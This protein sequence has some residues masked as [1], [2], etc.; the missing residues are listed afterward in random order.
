MWLY[1][2][3]IVY[4]PPAADKDIKVPMMN[5]LNFR[6]F[7]DRKVR[8]IFPQCSTPLDLLWIRSLISVTR[9]QSL[10]K[11]NFPENLHDIISYAGHMKLKFKKCASI[12]TEAPLK[13]SICTVLPPPQPQLQEC[14]LVST[15][16]FAF[17]SRMRRDLQLKVYLKYL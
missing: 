5:D 9:S 8:V 16:T 17:L 13:C 15:Y 7:D 4:L 14:P 12:D 11:T 2:V 10:I 1:R 6:S 3:K